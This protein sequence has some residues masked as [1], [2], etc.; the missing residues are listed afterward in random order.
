[1]EE[2]D[3]AGKTPLT[4]YSSI[5]LIKLY[6]KVLYFELTYVEVARIF[7]TNHYVA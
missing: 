1:M 3:F 6:H 4:V 5:Y 2:V 7:T